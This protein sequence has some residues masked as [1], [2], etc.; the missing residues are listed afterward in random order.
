MAAKQKLLKVRVERSRWLNGAV[1]KVEGECD[2]Y[3]PLSSGSYLL[4]R[5]GLTCCLG[6]ACLAAGM[7]EKAI[8]YQKMPSNISTV[9]PASLCKLMDCEVDKDSVI[10]RQLANTNDDKD[11][12]PKEREIKIKALGLEAGIDFSFV[13]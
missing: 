8:K 3:H 9:L 11:L 5:D 13:A 12:Q 4:R 1:L 2:G 6:F 10:A 7:S